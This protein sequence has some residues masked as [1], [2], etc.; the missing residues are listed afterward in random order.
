MTLCIS[1]NFHKLAQFA[2]TFS[3][4]NFFFDYDYKVEYYEKEVDEDCYVCYMEI[5]TW[6][7]I[8]VRVGHLCFKLF[9]L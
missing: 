4:L 2:V 7:I 3:P 9:V 5:D 6:P 1:N 8:F